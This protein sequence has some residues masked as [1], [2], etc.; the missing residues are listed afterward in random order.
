MVKTFRIKGWFK[1]DG[2]RQGFT[3]EMRSMSK[4]D[5]IEC[6]YSEMGSKHGIE[7]NLTHISKIEEIKP[8]EAKDPRIRELAG[9][10]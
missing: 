1:H 10:E 3:K 7:R 5:A 8:K 4:E 9:E 2:N 6:L